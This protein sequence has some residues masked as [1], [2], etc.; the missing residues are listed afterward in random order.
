MKSRKTRLKFVLSA[1]KKWAKVLHKFGTFYIKIEDTKDNGVLL[2][3]YFT[4]NSTYAK[5]KKK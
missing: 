4:V 2:T 1:D 5:G 3:P